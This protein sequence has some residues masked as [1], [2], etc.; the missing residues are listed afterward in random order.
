MN[1]SVSS[2]ANLCVRL[3]VKPVACPEQIPIG[4]TV[5]SLTLTEMSSGTGWWSMSMRTTDSQTACRTASSRSRA[6][7]DD[8]SRVALTERLHRATALA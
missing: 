7:M 3:I 1:G 4:P 8:V 6:G 5:F 2:R